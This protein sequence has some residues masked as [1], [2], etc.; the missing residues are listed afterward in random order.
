MQ[1]LKVGDV[2]KLNSDRSPTMTVVDIKLDA[3]YP[4]GWVLCKWFMAGRLEEEAFPPE[5]LDLE[6]T[7]A[8]A[9]RDGVKK[10][11]GR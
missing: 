6:S 2:V 5:A 1:K 9:L 10:M 7:T 3:L 4:N 8:R 11:N